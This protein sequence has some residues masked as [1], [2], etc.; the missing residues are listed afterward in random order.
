MQFIQSFGRFWHLATWE[1]RRLG[2]NFFTSLVSIHRPWEEDVLGVYEESLQIQMGKM[3]ALRVRGGSL[4]RS[5]I[6]SICW[7]R[8]KPLACQKALTGYLK[9][10]TKEKKERSQRFYNWCHHMPTGFLYRSIGNVWNWK[11]NQ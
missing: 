5:S 11:M 1:T 2:G 3:R 4:E 8:K 10:K 9:G 7:Q 6:F